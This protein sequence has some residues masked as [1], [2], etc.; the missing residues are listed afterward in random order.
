MVVDLAGAWKPVKTA[1]D[2]T[3][4]VNSLVK[5]FLLGRNQCAIVQLQKG[6]EI[7]G[8]LDKMRQFPS[9]FRPLMCQ[10][11]NEL[12][13]ED[14]EAKC[15]Y[16]RSERGSNSFNVE[17]VTLGFWGDFLVDVTEVECQ[18]QLKDI[19]MF[20]SGCFEFPPLGL[21]LKVKF[22]HGERECRFPKANTCACELSLPISHTSY[23]SFKDDMIFA[24]LNTKGFGHA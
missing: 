15:I 9:L 17:N 22:L 12:T 7:L 4:I 6:L 24:I 14:L 5:W 10:S 8:V 20:V 16:E 19:L 1:Q 18:L 21:K 3:S 2:K 23:T 13:V 11:P